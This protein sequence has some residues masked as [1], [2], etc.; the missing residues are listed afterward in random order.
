MLYLGLGDGSPAGDPNG[1]GQNLGSLLGSVIRIDV[2]E[3]S[4]VSPY[5][6]PHDNPF[7]DVEGARPEIWAYGFRNPWRMA[8]DPVTGALWAGEVGQSRACIH[9]CVRGCEAGLWAGL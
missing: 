7:V 6:I 5:A 2:S 8:F 9:V 1:L 4:A 3:A